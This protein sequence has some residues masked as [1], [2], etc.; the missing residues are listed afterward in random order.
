MIETLSDP[1]IRT[2]TCQHPSIT[3]EQLTEREALIALTWGGADSLVC[4]DC[5]ETLYIHEDGDTVTVTD[6]P[7]GAGADP[8]GRS[9]SDWEGH[10]E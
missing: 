5:G 10:A 8:F 9:A 4:P 2:G 6:E 3:D 7:F 1:F